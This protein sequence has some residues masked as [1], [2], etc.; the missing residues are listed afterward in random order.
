MK[1]SFLKYT[2]VLLG[3]CGVALPGCGPG[4]QPE[5]PERGSVQ[6]YLDENP[7]VAARIDE[8]EYTEEED[9]GT[10]E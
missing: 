10:G 7:D 1:R 6:A 2:V 8:G 3:V 5:G 4:T 9:D